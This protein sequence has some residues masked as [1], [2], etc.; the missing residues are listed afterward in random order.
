L[1]NDHFHSWKL[2]L[3]LLWLRIAP[4]LLQRVCKGRVA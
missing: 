3:V 1:A 2:R 4:R